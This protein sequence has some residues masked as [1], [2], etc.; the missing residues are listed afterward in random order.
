[1]R[2]ELAFFAAVLSSIVTGFSGPIINQRTQ[3]ISNNKSSKV[4]ATIA[5]EK[6]KKETAPLPMELSDAE[7]LAELERAAEEVAS[8]TLDEECLVDDQGEPVSEICIDENLYARTKSRFKKL[9]TATLGIVR[10]G[11]SGMDDDEYD[12]IVGTAAAAVPEG[13]LLE[14]GWEAR[15]NSR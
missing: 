5:I 13:E 14:Q 7:I 11:R 15:G 9:V 10:G 3:H 8:D 2:F 12:D 6:K 1:M 4:F